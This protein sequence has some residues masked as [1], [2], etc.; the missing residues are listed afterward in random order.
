MSG[1][2]DDVDAVVAP[3]HTGVLGQDGNAAFFFQ[4]VGVH[5]ALF[6]L[7][8]RVEGVGLLQQLIDQSGLAMVDVGDNGDVA[9][10]LNHGGAPEPKRARIIQ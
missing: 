4:R 2:V 5:G 6:E 3:A 1:G 7:G 8:A 10:I 9:E